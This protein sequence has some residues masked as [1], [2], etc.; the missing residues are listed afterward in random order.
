[1]E[2]STQRQTQSLLESMNRRAKL[3]IRLQQTVEGLSVAAITYYVVGLIAVLARGL[4]SAGVAAKPEVATA[5]SVPIVALL[6]AVG[7]RRLRRAFSLSQHS[8]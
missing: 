7:V 5:I 1:V 6:V 2:V 4:A 3:Q 8:G